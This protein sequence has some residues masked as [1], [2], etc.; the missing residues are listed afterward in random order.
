MNALAIVSLLA[1]FVA[2]VL[3]FVRKT[4]VGI[5]SISLALISSAF[6]T[7]TAPS[8]GWPT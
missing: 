2:I 1:I 3:G 7:K 6:S 8:T 5:I 4:N